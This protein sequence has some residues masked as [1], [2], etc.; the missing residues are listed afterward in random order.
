MEAQ[1]TSQMYQGRLQGLVGQRV[2]LVSESEFHE[3]SMIESDFGQ[4]SQCLLLQQFEV[5][6]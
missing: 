2:C 3:N 4:K 1:A 6:R 5:D